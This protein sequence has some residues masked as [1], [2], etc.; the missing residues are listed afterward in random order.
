[1]VELAASVKV[2]SDFNTTNPP[3]LGLANPPGL[4]LDGTPWAE[5]TELL[6]KVMLL[7]LPLAT[8][9]MVPL[10]LWAELA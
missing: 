3:G 9:S 7:W 8:S 6:P 1:M 10:M 4:G 2:L 5:M